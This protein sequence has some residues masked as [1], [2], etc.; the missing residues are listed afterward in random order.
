VRSDAPVPVRGIVHG[1]S[2]SGATLF[3]EPLATVE[4]NNELV[5]LRE[6]ET[7]EIERILRAWTGLVREHLPELDM[8][9]EE[10]AWLDLVMA[11]GLLAR[12]LGAGAARSWPTASPLCCGPRATRCSSGR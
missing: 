10:I 5:Q 3:V 7:A 4:L 6:N 1:G 9:I 2:S 11:K 12:D 8:A